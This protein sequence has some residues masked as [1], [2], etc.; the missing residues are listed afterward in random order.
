MH[1]KSSRCTLRMNVLSIFFFFPF[2]FYYFSL[3]RPVTGSARLILSISERL[4]KR[5]CDECWIGLHVCMYV[6]YQLTNCR[7]AF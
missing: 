4:N 1:I 3:C 6:D 2:C 7:V 5:R